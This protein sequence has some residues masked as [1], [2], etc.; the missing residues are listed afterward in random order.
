MIYYVKNGVLYTADYMGAASKR[1]KGDNII[2]AFLNESN[3]TFVITRTNG[4]VEVIN[5]NGLVLRN[6]CNE[7]LDARFEGNDVLVREK[8]GRTTLRSLSGLVLKS[9]G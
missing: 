8:S 6:I 7:G 2:T 4:L 3:K 9:I 5:E 1:I